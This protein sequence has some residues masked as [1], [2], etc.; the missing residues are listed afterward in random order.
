MAIDPQRIHEARV[1]CAQFLA[2]DWVTLRE[3]QSFM[4]RLFHVAKCA[5]PARRFCAR[6]LDLLRAAQ[7]VSPQVVTEQARLDARWFHAFL[8]RCNSISLIKGEVA[9]LVAQVDPCPEGAGGVCASLGYYHFRFPKGIRECHFCIAALETFNILVACRLWAPSWH[10]KHVLLFSDSWVAVCAI[11]SGSVSDPLMRAV[12][13]EIWLLMAAFDVEFVV[14]HR[15]GAEMVVADALSRASLSRAHAD[16]VDK[17]VL[18]LSE[19]RFPIDHRLLAV[20]VLI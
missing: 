17:L 5:P 7:R 8:S 16:W 15:P 1:L 18:S 10:G 4:G 11:N 20:P 19:P 14:R 2:Q 12:M 13:R 3:L 6:L 9:E